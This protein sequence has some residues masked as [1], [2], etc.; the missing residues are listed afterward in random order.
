[1]ATTIWSQD[2][3]ESYP[4]SVAFWTAIAIPTKVEQCLTAGTNVLNAYV[5]NIGVAG[6]TLQG[7]LA[8]GADATTVT[9]ACDGNTTTAGD[10]NF[11]PG[12]TALN[13]A[14]SSQEVSYR[15]NGGTQC[16]TLFVDGHVQPVST[17]GV[18]VAN[19][20][21]GEPPPATTSYI[22]VPTGYTM[23]DTGQTFWAG[24]SGGGMTGGYMPNPYPSASPTWGAGAADLPYVNGTNTLAAA[25]TTGTPVTKDPTNYLWGACLT[26]PYLIFNENSG[27]NL[28]LAGA[29]FQLGATYTIAGLHLWNLNCS[30]NAYGMKNVTVSFS[31]DNGVTYSGSVPLTFAQGP[32]AVATYAGSTYMFGR[33]SCNAIKFSFPASGAV[34]N[35][36]TNAFGFSAICF[37]SQGILG[38]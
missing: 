25:L 1:M 20:Y 28:N 31:T 8:N 34:F 30:N 9:L 32:N 19:P 2:N 29:C 16:D 12:S 4:G 37:L 24:L 26:T 10:V 21:A 7:V 17:G 35:A 13:I 15:H 38:T 6:A 27:Y 14:W 23:S 18:T 3:N 33:T 36:S 11:F 5:Y 22:V